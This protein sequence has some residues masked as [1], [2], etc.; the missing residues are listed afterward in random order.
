MRKFWEN[1][2]INEISCLTVSLIF[3]STLFFA[4]FHEFLKKIF[5]SKG[6]WGVAIS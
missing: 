1:I 3:P 4:L 6:G 5:N 2:E